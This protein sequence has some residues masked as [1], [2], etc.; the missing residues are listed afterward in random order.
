M[1]VLIIEGGHRLAGTLEAS[2]AKNSALPALVAAAFSDE[3]VYLEHVPRD[4]DV[5]TMIHLLRTLGVTVE[6]G[7]GP[8][9]LRVLGSTLNST[10]APYELVRRMRAS[11]YVA[12]LLLARRGEATVPLPG[13]CA[14]G[15]RPVDYH[16]RGFEQLGAAIRIEGG[17]M[18]ASA[19]WG[20]E[21]AEIHLSRPSVGA[22][23][24]LMMASVLARGTTVIRNAAREPE[25]VDIANLLN[26]M[27]AHVRGAGTSLIRIKGTDR[28][29]GT[30]YAVIPDRIETATWLLAGAI[31]GGEVTVR[32]ALA[33]HL[34]LPLM[35][36]REA[37]Y[38]IEVTPDSVALF[39]P[40]GLLRPHPVD[41]ETAPYPGFPTDLQQPFAALLAV[42]DGTSV[43]RE[44]I[45]DRFRYA[46]ELR[47]MGADI[48]V[49]RDTA[50]IQGVARLTGARVEAT[51][52]RGGAA[53]L[54]A[55]LAADG[56]TLIERPEIIDRGYEALEAK[57]RRLGG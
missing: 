49:E 31:T 36:L 19:P 55:A 6:V 8:G 50:I 54:L 57:V 16:L 22:T 3:P 44:T 37:G 9:E 24:Q 4:A 39:T 26:S 33:E 35:K 21:G 53:L 17:S 34:E 30:R 1:A 56:E 52:L 48:R 23:I 40:P 5:A 25:V 43:V 28:L 32:G 20:L 46:D 45:F 7:T 18:R 13:G 15:S 2:G 51:D 29:H 38:R 42:A 12:G 14:L 10:E 11:F 47:R 27:G 41:L